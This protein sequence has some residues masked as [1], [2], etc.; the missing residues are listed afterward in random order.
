V[1]N[2]SPVPERQSIVP[3]L[4]V[5]DASAAL[6]F[7]AE[8]FG[9]VERVRVALPDGHIAHAE[10]ELAGN[11][12]WLADE[13][14]VLGFP[15]PATLGGAGV[16][17]YAYVPDVEASCARAVGAGATLL[18]PLSDQ[19]WG[20]RTATVRDPFGHV[21]TLATRRRSMARDAAAEAT[22]AALLVPSRDGGGEP[23]A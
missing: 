1:T 2:P 14:P 3:Y 22:R 21:W 7:Y 20:D 12:V 17:V 23:P 6:A 9:A 15:G 11:L 5:R 8:A 13:A 19:P 4:L 18:R 10:T 16:M